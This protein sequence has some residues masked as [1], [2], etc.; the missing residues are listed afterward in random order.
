MRVKDRMFSELS[1]PDSATHEITMI[2]EDR[3]VELHLP[4][5][6]V[7]MPDL[8]IVIPALNEEITIQDFLAWCRQG[9]AAAGIVTEI[10]IVD[11]G[12]DRTTELALAGG[13]RVLRTPRR[14]LGRAY[15]DALP[16]VRGKYMILGDCDCTYDFRDLKPFVENF[17]AGNDFIMGSRFRGSIEAGSMPFL[18]RRLGTPLTT[19]ILNRVYSSKFTDIHCGMRGVTKEA[20][21]RMDLQSQS[22]EY[23]SEMVLKAVRL[24][25]QITEVPVSFLKDRDGRQ[26]HHK[27]EGWS[28]PWKAAW[29]NLRAMFIYGADFFLFRPGL[30]LLTLGLMMTIPLAAGPITIGKVTFSIYWLLLGVT[31]S[32][33]GLQ[34]FY[35][36]CLAKLI[37]DPAEIASKRWLH[38]FR[39]TRTTITSVALFALGAVFTSILVWRWIADDL[40]LP[41]EFDRVNFLAIFG[42][43]LMIAAFM[44]FT[45]MLVLH[46]ISRRLG[47]RNGEM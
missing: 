43:F 32:V 28:S 13:A 6:D 27:R 36:G 29:I 23:A 8:S 7:A 5:N 3:D 18:H 4:A 25:L 22:W 26:S 46:A 30:I 19:W 34:S 38:I 42:L 21:S 47:D 17:R 37:Y 16:Y 15:L 1:A 41:S 39:Y 40:N 9:I 44:S 2:A 20:F 14:G 12:T 10:L 45:F 11:S 31:I 24:K 35:L 33:V